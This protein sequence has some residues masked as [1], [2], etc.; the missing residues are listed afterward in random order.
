MLLLLP[1]DDIVEAPQPPKSIW[2]DLA[3][4]ESLGCDLLAAG[5]SGV[6]HASLEPQASAVDKFEKDVV[7]VAGARGVDFGA[8]CA[9]AERLKAELMVE[10]G[11][12][13]AFGG[14]G[15][16][17]S[18]RLLEVLV[19]VGCSGGGGDVV[20]AKLKSPKTSE[21]LVLRIGGW[22]GFLDIVC[23]F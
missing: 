1:E 12:A 3:A 8:G 17:K 2:G 18:K 5:G 4:V 11:G 7:V 14:E 21:E 6:A 23:G 15:L 13:A 10:V 19:V 9:G 16:E 22:E 20:V